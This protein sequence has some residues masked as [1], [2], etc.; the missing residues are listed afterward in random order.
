[1]FIL[2]VV[3]SLPHSELKQLSNSISN[4]KRNQVRKLF[5]VILTF[6]DGDQIPSKEQLFSSAYDRPYNKN[7]DYLLRKELQ[8]LRAAIKEFLVGSEFDIACRENDELSE[9]FYSKALIRLKLFNEV[10]KLMNKPDICS[11]TSLSPY[12]KSEQLFNF[13]NHI[14]INVKVNLDNLEKIEHFLSGIKQNIAIYL[15]YQF[16]SMWATETICESR[17]FVISDVNALRDYIQ[18][19]REISDEEF[20]QKF[21]SDLEQLVMDSENDLFNYYKLNAR[22]FLS[23]GPESISILTKIKESLDRLEIKGFEKDAHRIM[24]EGNLASAYMTN[25]QYHEAIKHYDNQIV[26]CKNRKQPVRFT[27]ILNLMVCYL[28][29]GRYQ[30]GIDLFGKYAPKLKG[31]PIIDIMRIS[32]A[33]CFI[34]LDNSVSAVKVIE[35]PPQDLPEHFKILHRMIYA[36]GFFIDDEIQLAINEISNLNAVIYFRKI[37]NEDAFRKSAGLLLEYFKIQQ[38]PPGSSQDEKRKTLST[39][40]LDFITE[41]RIAEINP[42]ML[43]LHK[44]L[45][46]VN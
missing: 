44:Q 25:E 27:T 32:L 10:D 24:S 3:K 11:S 43:W 18:A 42:H 40:V 1:M 2:K 41:T 36:I 9:M 15:Q 14:L 30:D 28:Y 35:N 8:Y 23:N 17:K 46:L 29:T 5:D 21:F 33:F 39:N 22:L 45:E 4:H 16:S 31:D 37:K 20:L 7:E 13:I 34:F 38:L 12:Y 6:R 26:L 19:Q